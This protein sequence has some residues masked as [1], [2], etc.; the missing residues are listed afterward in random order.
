MISWFIC[1]Y[2]KIYTNWTFV[3]LENLKRHLSI[4]YR[5]EF[6]KSTKLF[7]YLS[8]KKKHERSFGTSRDEL[9]GSPKG[10]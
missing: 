8:L 9:A 2:V 10:R 4:T 3:K 7:N 5:A 6:I 1:S